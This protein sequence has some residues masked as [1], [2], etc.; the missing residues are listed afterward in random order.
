ML[1]EERKRADLVA[2]L[3]QDD[4]PIVVKENDIAEISIDNI[5]PFD[6]QPFKLYEGER[7]DDMVQSIK[8]FGVITPLIVRRIS[9]ERFECLAGHNRINAS[10][11][12]GLKTVPCV[13]KGNMD[14]KTALTYVIETNLMQR[15]FGDLLPSEK[16]QVLYVKHKKLVDERKIDE[17]KKELEIFEKANFI[18][19]T[20]KGVPVGHN[21]KSRDLIGIEYSMSSTNVAR[22]LRIHELSDDLKEKVDL[23]EISIR[24]G[25]DLSYITKE[26]MQIVE[27][28]LSENKYKI[29]M[30]KAIII[31][32]YSKNKKLDEVSA[33]KILSGEIYKTK[34]MKG[35]NK[36]IVLKQKVYKKYFDDGEDEKIILEKIEQG[37][38]LQ[39]KYDVDYIEEAIK[40]FEDNK[41]K[42][43]K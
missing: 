19:K 1:E 33:E 4:E 36:N 25:V 14:Y 29:D 10:R 38:K 16:A 39:S 21:F 20:K 17:V 43:K 18:E 41:K 7:L 12:L 5:M 30:K 9:E 35:K 6:G 27:K 15:S 11:I 32:E 28:I 42:N 3:L 13:V 8:T 2:R 22:F 40:Y 23:G 26:E 34:K 24:S 31:R 37:L